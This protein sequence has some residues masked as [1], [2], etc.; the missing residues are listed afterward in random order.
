MD[1]GDLDGFADRDDR[2]NSVR[3]APVLGGGS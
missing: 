3:H 2:N 1:F